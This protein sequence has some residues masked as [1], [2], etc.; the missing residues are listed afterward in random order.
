MLFWLTA[1]L[2]KATDTG[3]LNLAGVLMFA[4]RPEW[5]KP[6]F[7]IKAIRYPG[8][9]IHA[10]DYLDTEDFGGPLRKIFDD[11]LAFVMRNLHKMQ[12][13]RGVNAPGL[14]E[15]PESVF[16]ELLVKTMTAMVVFLPL[17]FTGNRLMI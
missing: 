16:E 13:G 2:H 11:A 7:V 8:D 4:E 9:K 14:P 3:L 10:S 17:P 1:W 15:I 12:A 5:I 6:Q